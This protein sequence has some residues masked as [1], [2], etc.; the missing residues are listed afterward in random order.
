MNRSRTLP[1][2]LLFVALWPAALPASAPAAARHADPKITA[3]RLWATGHGDP[4]P[5]YFVRVHLRLRVCAVRGHTKV[6]VHETLSIGSNT[7]GEHRRTLAYEQTARCRR[8]T[9]K[10]RL[11]EEFLGVGTYRVAAKVRDK[12]GQLSAA[13]SRKVETND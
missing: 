10:W 12:D 3:M 13:R 1:P 11:R 8:R 2:A 7:F 4:G 6:R 5:D 9:F